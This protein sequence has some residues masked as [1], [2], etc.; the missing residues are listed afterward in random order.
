MKRA[1]NTILFTVFGP[2]TVAGNGCQLDLLGGLPNTGST[3]GGDEVTVPVV[4]LTTRNPTPG[5]SESVDLT[6]RVTSGST[7]GIAFEFSPA[8]GRLSVNRQL[9]TATFIVT[10]ADLGVLI[11]YTCR[12]SNA[13][14][15]GPASRAV[16]ISPTR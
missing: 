3:G 7:D 6:C 11:S 8:D 4:D 2:V 5:L 10:E 16:I 9:G 1:R 15:E 14:G 13:Q 12:A